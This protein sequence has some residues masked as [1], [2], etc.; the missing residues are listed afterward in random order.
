MRDH[1]IERDGMRLDYTCENARFRTNID[2]GET[3]A[4]YQS[5]GSVFREPLVLNEDDY[6]LWLEHVSDRR[7]PDERYYWLMWCD[8]SGHPTIPMSGILSREHIANMQR[9]L[10]SFI[11]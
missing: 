10:A 4:G 1:R 9:L 8:P 11:P 7:N 3:H 2:M 5:R 6:S